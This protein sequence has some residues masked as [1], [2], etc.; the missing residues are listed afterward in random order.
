MRKNQLNLLKALAEFNVNFINKIVYLKLLS[1]NK[2]S[3]YFTKKKKKFF[4]ILIIFFICPFLQ[5]GWLI[6]PLRIEGFGNILVGGYQI[7]T[8]KNQELLVGGA[9]IQRVQQIAGV[10][11]KQKI[12]KNLELTTSIF[13]A[14]R[15]KIPATYTRGTKF[16]P[17]YF[18][19]ISLQGLQIGGKFTKKFLQKN[20]WQ[21]SFN[22]INTEQKFHQFLDEEYQTL[23]DLQSIYV[24]TF[25]SILQQF[26]LKYEYQEQPQSNYQERGWQFFIEVKQN[27]QTTTT[28]YSDTLVTDLDTAIYIPLYSIYFVPRIFYSNAKVIK[29]KESNKQELAKIFDIKCKNSLVQT[30]QNCQSL[31]DNLT[32]NLASHNRYGTASPLGGISKLR[33]E[34]FL[35]YKGA[36]TEYQSLEVRYLWKKNTLLME[37]VIFWE[38]GRAFDKDSSKQKQLFVTSN[39]LEYRFHLPA[40]LTYKVVYAQSQRNKVLQLSVASVW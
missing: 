38:R 15:L 34:S 6:A 37:P 40:D 35:R 16:A 2:L 27:L 10:N 1:S 19:D 3:Y 30:T 9:V 22:L 28:V 25:A 21:L 8:S 12:N 4:C 23:L 14:T 20:K 5:A 17:L 33:S 13:Q 11:A 31:E 24:G 7:Q 39:G 26:S 29:K 32:T 36:H 18:S